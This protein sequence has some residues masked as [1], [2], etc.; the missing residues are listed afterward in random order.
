MAGDQT[1]W[2]PGAIF[3]GSIHHTRS[4]APAVDLRRVGQSLIS[5]SGLGVSADA[6]EAKEV[7]LC[8][9]DTGSNDH[10]TVN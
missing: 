9:T 6:E 10:V 4:P 7:D 2:T 8:Q 3:A 1:F 5:A